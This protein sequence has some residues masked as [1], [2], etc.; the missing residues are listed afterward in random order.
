[1]EPVLD[2][3]YVDLKDIDPNFTMLD[4][5]WYDLRI[6]KA[7]LATYEAKK[8]TKTHKMGDT[9]TRIDLAFTV[10]DHPKFTG[11]KI[12]ERLFPNDF[13]FKVLRRI[14][15]NTGIQQTGDLEQWLKELAT[16]GPTIR[17]YVEKV[18]D[19]NFDGTLNPKT[20][21]VDPV[22][23]EQTPGEKNQVAWK[24]GVQQAT[25]I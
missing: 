24:M 14:A 8:D 20:A 7:E 10:V 4:P 22:T 2:F 13:S 25:G 23:G 1:M 3:R 5:E 17:L 11:R 6:S 16:V 15:D 12:W 21:K 18:P 9:C 19:V